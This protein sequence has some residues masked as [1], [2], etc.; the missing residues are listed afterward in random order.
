MSA[1]N[2]SGIA[3]A[4]AGKSATVK[5]PL[6]TLTVDEANTNSGAMLGDV[7]DDMASTISPSLAMLSCVE[8]PT[9]DGEG[10]GAGACCG[11][12][13]ARGDAQPC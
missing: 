2:A 1:T 8:K 3:S 12:I 11:Y 5:P 6:P 10:L 9:H 4:N 13:A 7:E